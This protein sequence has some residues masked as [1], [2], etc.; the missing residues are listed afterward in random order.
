MSLANPAPEVNSFQ[1]QLTLFN[2]HE[3]Y[4]AQDRSG[5]FALCW[6]RKTGDYLQ[7]KSYPL[8][9]LPYVIANVDRGRDTYLSQCEF[10]KPN[11]RVVHLARLG[12]LWVDLDTYHSQYGGEDPQR[13]IDRLQW[14]CEEEGIPFPSVILHSGRGLYLKWALGTALP[15]QAL[16]RWLAVQKVLLRHFAGYGADKNASDASRILRLEGTVN[17][18]SGETVRVLYPSRSQDAQLYDFDELATELLPYSREEVAAHNQAQRDKVRS[19]DERLQRAKLR[20]IEGGGQASKAF[21]FSPIQ[22]NHDRL[23]DLRTLAKLRGWLDG[24]PD[25]SRDKFLFAASC[26]MAWYIAPGQIYREAQAL[27]REWCPHWSQSRVNSAVSAVYG[28]AMESVKGKKNHYKGR[29]YDPRYTFSNAT[30]VELLSITAEE[31]RQTKTIMGE[32]E[33]RQRHTHDARKK[34]HERGA[35]PREAYLLSVEQK[36]IEARLR[37]AQG[38]SQKEIAEALGA[39]RTTVYRWLRKAD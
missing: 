2:E 33:A 14:F 36:R 38:Q 3:L 1:Q 8:E 21:K 16:P 39:D 31:E 19:R 34:R 37:H 26:F 10:Y 12:L 20:S 22:L 4:H 6:R 23:T 27:A 5:F 15:A 11:R 9:W 24:N 25:G 7:Q 18:R 32:D 17:T 29:D 28:R 30:L 13:T 35:V